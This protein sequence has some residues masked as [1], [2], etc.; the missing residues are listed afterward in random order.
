MALDNIDF[1]KGIYNTAKLLGDKSISSDATME[2]EGYEG[3]LVLTKQFPWPTIGAAGEIDIAGPLGMSMFQPQQLK[4]AHQGPVT[5]EETT[6]G[7]I[8]AFMESVVARKGA[9][10]NATVYEGTPARFSRGYK[11]IDAFFVPDTPDRDMENR[12]QVTLISGTLFY[13]FFNETLPG[14]IV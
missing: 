1:L 8:H 9:R 7:S 10:F 13:H 14:N 3:L 5:F 4:T 2:I 12:S 11:L 6:K